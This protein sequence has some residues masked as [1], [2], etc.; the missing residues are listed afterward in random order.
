M[1]ALRREH[2]LAEKEGQEERGC[3]QDERVEDTDVDEILS[4]AIWGKET[5]VEEE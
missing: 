3:V 5:V 1:F 2:G 4:K